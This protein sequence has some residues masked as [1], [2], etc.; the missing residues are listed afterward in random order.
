MLV[1]GSVQARLSVDEQRTL[2]E[3]VQTLGWSPSKVVRES[4]HLM[5]AAHPAIRNR[6][7]AGLGQ[8]SSG[9]PD[10]GSNKKHLKGFGR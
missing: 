6:R 10:L 9:K 7:I 1:K 2:A 8:F 5:A 3:L 4:L